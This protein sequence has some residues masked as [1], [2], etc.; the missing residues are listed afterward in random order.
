MNK[1]KALNRKTMEFC[2]SKN[3]IL[4]RQSD[5]NQNCLAMKK[6]HLH[7][8]GISP[9]AITFLAIKFFVQRVTAKF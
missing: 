1:V 8:K 7:E 2:K 3:L 6:L 4:I 5:F 9:L